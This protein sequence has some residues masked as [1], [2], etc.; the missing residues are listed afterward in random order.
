MSTKRVL[1]YAALVSAESM[2]ASITTE[3]S[4]ILHTDRVGYQIAWTGTPTGAF[5][6]EISND[7]STWVEL[8]LSTAIAAAGSADEAFIDAETA[9]KFIRLVYTR[10][11][12]TGTLN[13]HIT[14][15]SISG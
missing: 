11:S 10:S 4:N 14:A 1:D 9:A 13:V 7:G 15:K 5:T 12:G 6:V 2:G 8:T 3:A